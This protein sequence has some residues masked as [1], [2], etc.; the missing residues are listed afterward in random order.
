MDLRRLEIFL[1]FSELG[2]VRAT[3]ESL[4]MSSSNVSEQLALVERESGTRLF[5]RHGRR[6]LL[7]PDGRRLVGHARAILDRVDEALVDLADPQAEPSGTVRVGA[8]SSAVP[9]IVL[10]ALGA[11]AATAPRVEVEI[12]E[13]P[14]EQAG[15]ALRRGAADVAVVSDFADSPL[16]E[17][18]D[19]RVDLLAGDPMALVVGR[20]HPLAGDGRVALADLAG[21]RW[22][23]DTADSYLGE[24]GLRACRRAGFEPRVV[25]RMSS[26]QVLL[27]HVVTAGSVAFLPG[28]AVRDPRVL[29]LPTDPPLPDRR[30]SLAS[31][32]AGRRRPSVAVVG[33]ALRAATSAL[34]G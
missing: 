33:E 22:A 23:F 24:V 31:T 3:A 14:P 20:S 32:A 15:S 26:Y 16:P 2:N 10:P 27:E 29:A 7:T 6:L 30:I 8:F 11:L 12:L 4:H 21:Q 19:I 25:A 18:P 28:L 17:A 13:L 9:S 5:E 34:R 1:R